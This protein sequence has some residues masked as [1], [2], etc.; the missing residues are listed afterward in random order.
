M[1][2]LIG[3]LHFL[4]WYF[5][6]FILILCII[7]FFF[8]FFNLTNSFCKDTI[9]ARP[10]D[11]F[12]FTRERSLT[13][14]F[15]ESGLEKLGLGHGAMVRSGFQKDPCGKWTGP[16]RL[17]PRHAA[18]SENGLLGLDPRTL[19]VLSGCPTEDLLYSLHGSFRRSYSWSLSLFL[20]P[21]RFTY[22]SFYTS[23]R[24]MSFVHV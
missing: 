14:Q 11:I 3:H 20:P 21:T 9:P 15:V 5:R 17:K 8:E 19:V 1:N 4:T 7:F 12:G 10:S 6:T 16:K 23:V 2:I 22:F 24:S 18:T 13:I